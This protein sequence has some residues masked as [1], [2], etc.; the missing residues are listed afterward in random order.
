MGGLFV[1]VIQLPFFKSKV[2]LVLALVDICDQGK[3]NLKNI[4]M[5]PL[6]IIHKNMEICVGRNMKKLKSCALLLGLFNDTA[7]VKQTN[8][9][10]NSM[11]APQKVKQ[12]CHI[13]QQF[14]F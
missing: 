4:W 13:T 9:Q 3:S 7:I 12:K 14:H 5:Y 6:G 8:K 1:G 2:M 10:T 11:T